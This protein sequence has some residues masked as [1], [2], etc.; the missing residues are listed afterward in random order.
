MK[1]VR[2]KTNIKCDG[3]VKTVT[4]FLAK[5]EGL[6]NWSV[7]LLDPAR[8]MTASITDSSSAEEIQKALVAAGYSGEVLSN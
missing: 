8:T 2:L 1:S 4:P 6:E 5:V 7:D 3:C